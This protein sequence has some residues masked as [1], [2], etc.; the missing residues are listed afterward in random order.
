MAIINTFLHLSVRYGNS[1]YSPYGYSLY[2]ML[3]CATMEDIEWGY[4]LGQMSVDIIEE[5]GAKICTAKILNIFGNCIRHWKKPARENIDLAIGVQGFSSGLETGDIENGGYSIIHYCVS[6]LFLGVHLPEL[7]KKVD[8]YLQILTQLKHQYATTILQIGRLT[9][10]NLQENDF[11][12]FELPEYFQESEQLE[13]DLIANKSFTPLFLLYVLRGLFSYSI[14]K[15]QAA[16]NY[17][18]LAESYVGN[19]PGLLAVSEHKFYYSL[20]LL[21]QYPKLAENQQIEC[22]K[23]VDDNQQ[24]MKIWVNYAPENFLHQYEL[25]EAEKARKFSQTWQVAE[26]YDRAIDGAKINGYIQLEALGNELA[27]K[28]L[29]RLEQ[30]KSC[31]S[32]YAGSLLWLRSLGSDSQNY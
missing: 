5:V 23:I 24:K 25:V 1:K 20:S 26:S 18:K 14:G 12:K 7:E 16:V 17:L 32:L 15:Y 19:A 3:L 27:A 2:G 11:S 29:P 31:R 28:I 30:R 4:Q 21:A 13:S 22:L 9:I 10:L 8:D 6:L